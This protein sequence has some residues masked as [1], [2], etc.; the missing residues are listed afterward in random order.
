LLLAEILKTFC[1]SCGAEPMAWK[2][3]A[4][5]RVGGSRVEAREAR[6]VRASLGTAGE[7]RS[8]D[9]DMLRGRSWWGG[10]SG[11]EEPEEV[12]GAGGVGSGGVV[13]DG[14]GRDGK[15]WD[16]ER[17]SWGWERRFG[18]LDDMVETGG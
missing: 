3:M 10:E 7:E 13:V 5:F 9:V 17:R 16:S 6:A 8:K 4:T 12:W 14:W 1:L 15:S 11:V 18:L 2:R